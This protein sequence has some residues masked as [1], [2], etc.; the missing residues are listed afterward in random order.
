MRQEHD[1]VQVLHVDEVDA[2]EVA[3][4]ILRRQLPRTEWAGGWMYDFAPGSEWPEV[5]VHEG[6]ERYYVVSG[7]FIDRGHRLGPG[8]YVVFAPGSSH[9]PRTETGARMLGIS[10]LPR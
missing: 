7:E 10:I 9:R 4:G 2:V 3:P 6:E 8:S 5:D 1:D